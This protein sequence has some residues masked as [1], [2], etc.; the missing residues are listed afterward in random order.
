MKYPFGW[1]K[2]E[3]LLAGGAAALAAVGLYLATKPATTSTTTVP[4][5]GTTLNLFAQPLITPMPAATATPSAASVTG[6]PPNAAQAT[7]QTALR[8]AP[9]GFAAPPATLVPGTTYQF[10]STVGIDW[11]QPPYWGNLVK[12]A[13]TNGIGYGPGEWNG[14]VLY[15]GPAGATP[16]RL[17]PSGVSLG[18]PI[19]SPPCGC[20][21]SPHA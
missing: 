17:L 16:R 20:G 5:G 2:D 14:T 21:A 12:V 18:G 15:T 1:S 3:T 8:R 10:W 13:S 6:A 9:Q 4:A 19:A 11:A 7:V